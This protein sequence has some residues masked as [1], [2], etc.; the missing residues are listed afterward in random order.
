MQQDSHVQRVEKAID[1]HL[2]K[3]KEAKI[4]TT[5]FNYLEVKKPSQKV[6][7]P[8]SFMCIHNACGFLNPDRCSHALGECCHQHWTVST[9]AK[10]CSR[11]HLKTCFWKIPSQL[12]DED[13]PSL[14]FR[15]GRHLDLK[16]IPFLDGNAHRGFRAGIRKHYEACHKHF[17]T[18][19]SLLKKKDKER[20]MKGLRKDQIKKLDIIDYG[21][22]FRKRGVELL[23]DDNY[24]DFVLNEM[25]RE[26]R[27]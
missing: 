26:P 23:D 12:N 2:R 13:K 5:F 16:G 8:L 22:R 10:M 25:K 20:V 18:P 7:G 1:A 9:K 27:T 15:W 17:E 3:C 4:S 24:E 11:A 19:F 14:D 21:K 6:A